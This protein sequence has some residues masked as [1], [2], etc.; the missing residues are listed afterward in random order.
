MSGP[1]VSRRAAVRWAGV[2]SV[3]GAVALGGCDL[4]PRSSPTPA[5]TPTPDHDERILLA[6]RA[7][8]TG[9]I[10]RLRAT[11][12][13][14]S[15]VDPDTFLLDLEQAHV[16]QLAALDAT[17][18]PSP[19]PGVRP[20]HDGPRLVARE[21]VAVDRFTTWA[22]HA[23]S[24]DLARVLAATAAGIPTLLAGGGLL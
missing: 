3:T 7:E 21:L 24:G 8:L 19:S 1:L 15:Q 20:L 17:P 13:D 10:A 23:W 12:A 6:A 2:V 22:E 4:D 5:A 9:L 18:H 14:P 16:A 11:A